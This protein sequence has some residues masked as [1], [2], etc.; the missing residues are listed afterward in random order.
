M[1]Q[2]AA[3]LSAMALSVAATPA[4]ASNFLIT[5]TGIVT[6]GENQTGEFGVPGS[7]VG[8]PY[9]AVYTLT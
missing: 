6:T 8:R 7:L 3:L 4:Q 5:Y 2:A 1:K 9:T